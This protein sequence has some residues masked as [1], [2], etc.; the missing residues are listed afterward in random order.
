MKRFSKINFVLIL[1]IVLCLLLIVFDN[2]LISANVT[3]GDTVSNVTVQKY[4]AISFST[5]LSSGIVFGTVNLLPVTNIN[6]THNYDDG[7]DGTTFYTIVSNDSNANA[8]FCIRANSSLTSVS[9]DEI[10]LGNETYSNST[11]SNMTLPSVA[12]EV[13][14]TTSYVKAGNNIIVGS[15]NYFRFWLDIPAAQPSG[16]YNNTVYFKG[17]QTGVSC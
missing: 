11:N 6:A 9:A 3:E 12:D 10:G 13:S 14:L 8:D 2:L 15:N 17:V 4:L 7:S 16:D 5:N 1:I